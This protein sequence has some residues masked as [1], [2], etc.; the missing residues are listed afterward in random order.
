MPLALGIAIGRIGC[1]L[2]GLPDH[3][4]GLPTSLPW[5]VDFGDGIAR[6]PTQLY[7][8]VFLAW[9]AWYL[10]RASLRRPAAHV[11][12]DLFKL[13]MVSYL[14]LRLAIDFIKPGLAFL[15]LTSIQ[16][17]CLLTLVHYR[18]DIARWMTLGANGATCRRRD[19]L[20]P[21]LALT[22]EPACGR[23]SLDAGTSMSDA[24]PPPSPPQ[25]PTYPPRLHRRVRP[26]RRQAS[27]PS[28][29]RFPTWKQAFVIF[30][31]GS[32]LAV[33]ACFGCLFTLDFGSRAIP[34]S[35]ASR[36]SLPS[37]AFAGLLATSSASCSC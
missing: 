18:R 25:P 26:R 31:G 35:K 17:V 37:L 30:G 2:A 12:G 6:H 13:F 7:E 5:G 32:V 10:S 15:G 28:S 1:F 14:G 34:R 22:P 24:Q 27:L 29:Q 8:A 20:M 19:R 11:N 3:T 33:S 4:Y 36:W 9:L 16:W 23:D 21:E